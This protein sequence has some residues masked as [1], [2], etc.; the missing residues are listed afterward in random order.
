MTEDEVLELLQIA[1]EYD[2]RTI[3]RTD[4]MA[5]L[6]AA[7]RGRWTAEAAQEAVREHYA[8]STSFV[9]PGHVTELLRAE[10]RQ[11]PDY[12]QQQKALPRPRRDPEVI[13]AGIDRVFA[14]LAAKQAIRDGSDPGEAAEIAQGEAGARRQIR[15]IACPYCKAPIGRPCVIVGA[16]KDQEK[17]GYHPARVELAMGGAAA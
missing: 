2:H 3:G 8:R 15:S 12:A 9:M 6:D 10:R 11:P 4:M 16:R 14:A 17:A 13:R 1:C 5:W 7:T